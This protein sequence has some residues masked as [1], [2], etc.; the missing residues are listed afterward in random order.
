LDV[1]V[2]IDK[3]GHQGQRR[4]V[5]G[6]CPDGVNSY[7]PRAFDHYR[8]VVCNASLAIKESPDANGGLLSFQ[9]CRNGKTKGTNSNIDPRGAA[10]NMSELRLLVVLHSAS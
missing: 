8:S 9:G 2:G 4:E 10:L 1:G 6:R 7:D 3:A 5:I